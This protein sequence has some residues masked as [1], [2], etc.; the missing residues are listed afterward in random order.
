MSTDEAYALLIAED[1]DTFE[2]CVVQARAVGRKC[3]LSTKA[4]AEIE[5][6]LIKQACRLLKIGED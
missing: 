2:D 5:K 3:R 4:V 1:R 6:V